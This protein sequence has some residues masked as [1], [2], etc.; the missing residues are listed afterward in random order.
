LINNLNSRELF[1]EAPQLYNEIKT[2]YEVLSDYVH[3]SAGKFVKTL[4]GKNAPA[5]KFVP[6][7]FDFIYD[8][9]LKVLDCI[10]FVYIKTMAKFFDFEMTEEFL[11]YVGQHVKLPQKLVGS[12]LK[13]PFSKRLSAGIAFSPITEKKAIEKTE[14]EEGLNAVEPEKVEDSQQSNQK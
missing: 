5:W 2:T 4:E 3:P 10:E 11:D 9:G 12:F 6:E 8:L 13:L 1:S 7:E 14:E